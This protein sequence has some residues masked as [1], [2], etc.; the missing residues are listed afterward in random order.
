MFADFDICHR[1]KSLQ[2]LYSVTL[3]YFSKINDSNRD[4]PTLVNTHASVTS[5]NTAA[6]RLA[7]Y[8][9]T[10]LPTA[11]NAHLS[12]TSAS[13]ASSFPFLTKVQMI[14]KLFLQI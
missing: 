1:M 12:V 13:S 7:P 9:G 10:S 14:T 8:P 3:T 4:L 2:K 6:H 11:A 5:A